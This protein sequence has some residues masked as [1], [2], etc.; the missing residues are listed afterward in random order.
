[1]IKKEL[2]FEID[3]V[4]DDKPAR[5]VS[6]RLSSISLNFLPP[7]QQHSEFSYKNVK[8]K[9]WKKN[10]LLLF[11]A[12]KCFLLGESKVRKSKVLNSEKQE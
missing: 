7:P 1:M 9:F 2:T 4:F 8:S 11:P 12:V 3:S 10:N 6:S 5:P